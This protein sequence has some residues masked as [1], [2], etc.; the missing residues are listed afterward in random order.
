MQT[1]HTEQGTPM[2]EQP[3]V[4][5]IFLTHHHSHPDIPITMDPSVSIGP[6]PMARHPDLQQLVYPP[7]HLVP[8]KNKGESLAVAMPSVT[9][10]LSFVKSKAVSLDRHKDTT[11]ELW[12]AVTSTGTVPMPTTDKGINQTSSETFETIHA[13]LRAL[14]RSL[15][16]I[17]N[18]RV[19]RA[20]EE[21]V[22]YHHGTT[23]IVL[24]NKKSINPS[25]ELLDLLSSSSFLIRFLSHSPKH[26]T[27]FT[28]ELNLVVDHRG[29][30]SEKNLYSYPQILPGSNSKPGVY[31]PDNPY[32]APSKN[33]TIVLLIT[34]LQLQKILKYVETKT[35]VLQTVQPPHPM[36]ESLPPISETYNTNGSDLGSYTGL[37]VQTRPVPTWT[38]TILLPQLCN[39]MTQL[40]SILYTPSYLPRSILQGLLVV[41][42]TWDIG[43]NVPTRM[44]NIIHLILTVTMVITPVFVDRFI[45]MLTT[46]F[47][48]GFLEVEIDPG[49]YQEVVMSKNLANIIVSEAIVIFMTWIGYIRKPNNNY[50]A[51]IILTWDPGIQDTLDP[52]DHGNPEP[53]DYSHSRPN[54]PPHHDKLI[55]LENLKLGSDHGASID[56]PIRQRPGIPKGSLMPVR[57]LHILAPKR[58]PWGY[59][60]L[61][62]Q[63]WRTV[64]RSYRRWQASPRHR[65]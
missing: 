35:I 52:L 49:P 53:H 2:V 19:S 37:E 27:S 39:I 15:A 48:I 57:I 17:K 50:H 12:G 31:D 44:K 8:Q 38:K 32:G 62:G 56:G 65:R 23:N 22:D 34:Y 54:R 3:T 4:A 11:G 30:I 28:I 10:A 16:Q 21:N 6:H 46:L 45:R 1:C 55:I 51:S 43:E 40:I 9:P 25:R 64:P 41:L 5:R 36:K 42:L 20:L 18:Q 60:T 47:K 24:S 63:L 13:S 33:Q 61:V 29:L 26:Q 58:P 7:D 59:K 14:A